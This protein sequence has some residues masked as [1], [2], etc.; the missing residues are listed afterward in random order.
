MEETVFLT[1]LQWVDALPAGHRV[2]SS[3]TLVYLAEALRAMTNHAFLDMVAGSLELYKIGEMG[4]MLVSLL[5]LPLSRW[6]DAGLLLF[7]L[8]PVSDHMLTP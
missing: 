4:C 1:V 3:T 8:T 7:R 5:T 6:L 2:V